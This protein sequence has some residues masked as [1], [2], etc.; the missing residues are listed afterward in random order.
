[1][2]VG[3]D[4]AALPGGQS[5]A[6]AMK[7]ISTADPN[8]M[9]ELATRWQQAADQYTSSG[10]A[11]T[12]TSDQLHG[13]WTGAGATAFTNY[14]GSLITAGGSMSQALTQTSKAMDQAATA[15]EGY[16]NWASTRCEWLLSEARS[17]DAANPY[18]DPGQRMSAI[19]GLCQETG[20]D[21][22]KVVSSIGSELTELSGVFAQV[23]DQEKAF[24]GIN[25]PK[26][27][28]IAL[29][30]TVV[31]FPEQQKGPTGALLT[32]AQPA[33]PA[34]AATP[35]QSLSTPLIRR[36][37]TPLGA[38][39]PA[40][41]GRRMTPAT[42]AIRTTAAYTGSTAGSASIPVEGGLSVPAP[43]GQ[44]NDWIQQALQIL[45][46]NGVDTSQIS[47]ADLYTI[48][49]HESGGNPGAV[50]G[51][52]ANAAAGHPSMGL[53]QTIDSTFNAYKL[54]GH[55]NIMNPVDNIIAGVRY[56]IARY[57]SISAVPGVASVADGGSYVGY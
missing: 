33:T 21:L 7:T 22:Q 25:A 40:V 23:S 36:A 18:A 15:I 39:R 56:A 5:V 53:M 2:S 48:I 13:Q 54:A 38:M 50:N 42:P 28:G 49:E 26:G 16:Q 45:Q 30:R 52:D 19:A 14:V 35:A 47:P 27:V 4:V 43:S 57:G 31:Q 8:T 12:G 29:S 32:D 37:G 1:M 10:T 17:W 44:V 6:D 3:D 9:R 51:W 24:D 34:T 20:S 55:D 11:L 41:M 46:A